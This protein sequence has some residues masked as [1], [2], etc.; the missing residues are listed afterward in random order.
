MT[1]ERR[2]LVTAA[3][4]VMCAVWIAGEVLL[5]R[6]TQMADRT[7]GLSIADIE[8]RFTGRFDS[9]FEKQVQG[10]MRRYVKDDDQ[11]ALLVGWARSGA[12]EALYRREIAAI[13]D[14]RCVRCHKADGDA[15]FLPLDS[16]EKAVVTVHAKAAPPVR[17]QLIITKLHLFGIGAM[18]AAAGALF[19]SAR[20]RFKSWIISAGFVGLAL[21]FGSWWLMRSSLSFSYGRAVGHVLMAASFFLMCAGALVHTWRQPQ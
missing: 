15:A 16:F 21:D 12:G 7:P 10:D 2:T 3:I 9:L 11:L 5:Y 14:D 18:L 20:F 8:Q 13:L 17:Q 19:A 1:A 6:D 4:V